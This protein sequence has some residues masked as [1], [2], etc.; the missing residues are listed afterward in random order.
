MIELV[1][2]G[3]AYGGL[4]NASRANPEN[5]EQMKD[6]AGILGNNAPIRPIEKPER[7]L[8][9]E[10]QWD[11]GYLNQPEDSEYRMKLP[12]RLYYG[13]H[14]RLH[15]EDE[16]DLLRDGE[17]NIKALKELRILAEQGKE[18]RIWYS[19]SSMEL[20]GFYYLCDILKDYDVVV[21]A[22]E[23]PTMYAI[24]NKPKQIS[25]WGMAYGYEYGYLIE[26]E[27]IL[28][29]EE[30]CYVASLWNKL[31]EEN[32]PLRAVVANKLISVPEDFYDSLFLRYF[33]GDTMAENVWIEDIMSLCL[34]I[35]CGFVEQRIWSM[36][37]NGIIRL[38][39]DGEN[40]NE[41]IWKR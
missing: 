11:I 28:T 9:F 2:S 19:N 26:N 6:E 12:A 25:C 5:I 30:I 32:A 22:V 14:V 34:G 7:I 40:M 15:P 23:L 33:E 3:P 21:H 18:F 16:Q 35:S 13:H 24:G 38:L 29:K 27:R 1:F 37:E 4:V 41:R 20:C 8:P 39:K 10:F 17:N 31:V 36:G